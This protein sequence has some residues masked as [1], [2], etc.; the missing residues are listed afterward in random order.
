M[1]FFVSFVMN[2]RIIIT[3][4]LKAKFILRKKTTTSFVSVC[5]FVCL[6]VVV[7]LCVCFFFFLLFCFFD[8]MCHDE[9]EKKGRGFDTAL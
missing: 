7:F 9:K 6:L 1:Y 2:L 5:F 3:R 8:T 4:R